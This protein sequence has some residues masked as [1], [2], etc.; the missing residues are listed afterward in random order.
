MNQHATQ[1]NV[2]A[3][4]DAEQPL[5]TS[6][7]VLPWHDPNPGGEIAPPAKRCPVANGSHRGGADQRSKTGNLAQALAALILV[8]NAFDLVRDGLDVDLG[9]LPLLPQPIPQPA[10]TWAQV[11]LGIFHHRG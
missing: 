5:F 6:R 7:G 10:Q 1:I 9:L 11:L 4:T 3:F 2:A 8:T